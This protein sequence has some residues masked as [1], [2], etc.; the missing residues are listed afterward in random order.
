MSQAFLD[1]AEEVKKLKTKP[2]N[3]HLLLLYG[4]YK[5]VTVGDN[6][7]AE[8]GMFSFE[9]KAKWKAWNEHKGKPKDQAEKEYIAEVEALKKTNS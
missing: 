1:A 4:L 3:D 6:N 8:P 2:S 5:Q 7:T 9:G